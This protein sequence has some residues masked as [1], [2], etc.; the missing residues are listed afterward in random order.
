[1]RNKLS[2]GLTLLGISVMLISLISNVNAAGNNYIVYDDVTSSDDNI[3]NSVV[4]TNATYLANC[5]VTYANVTEEYIFTNAT[6]YHELNMNVSTWEVNQTINYYWTFIDPV[7]NES[8]ANLNQTIDVAITLNNTLINMQNQTQNQSQNQ[9]QVVEVN[10]FIIYD[11]FEEGP[12]PE[13]WNG[14][15]FL[16]IVIC[17][18]ILVFLVWGNT[19]RKDFI[20]GVKPFKGQNHGW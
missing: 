1:M 11:S 13:F 8:L 5:T 10:N 20:V 19:Q 17:G 18:I 2:K 6:T 4:V 15:I 12:I 14:S 7:S 9:S 16:T 3:V